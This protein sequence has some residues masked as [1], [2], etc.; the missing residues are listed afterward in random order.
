MTGR[1]RATRARIV[2][3][4][5][6]NLIRT[7]D[8]LGVQALQRLSADP[9]IPRAGDAAGAG[10]E[11]DFID[12]STRGLEL[13]N[14]TGEATHVLI[15]DAIDVEAEP[16][17]LVRLSG[18]EL[19]NLPGGWSVHQLGVVDWMTAQLLLTGRLPEIRVLGLQPAETGWGTTLSA[20]LEPHVGRLVDAAVEQLQQWVVAAPVPDGLAASGRPCATGCG[21]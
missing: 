2:V 11:I 17:M 1:G 9:R 13:V 5:V 10:F 4:G 14:E 16:G 8:G 7:D 18:Q 6:G 15:L 12:G 20:A 21:F 19:A 3:L